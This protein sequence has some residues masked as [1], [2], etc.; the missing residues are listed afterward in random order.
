MTTHDSTYPQQAQRG[1]REAAREARGQSP[2]EIRRDIDR[3]RM[4]I[5]R[6]I[7][8]LEDALSPTRL[9]DRCVTW[10]ESSFRR[11]PPHANGRDNHDADA[12]ARNL[13]DRCASIIADH[14]VPM[15]LIA[16][17][18]GWLV[19]DSLLSRRDQRRRPL[20][21]S[22]SMVP[23]STY[24]AASPPQRPT[25]RQTDEARPS[26]TVA[27]PSGAGERPQASAPSASWAAG[28]EDGRH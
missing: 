1:Q 5:D 18:V 27:A 14:P 13:G 21:R 2:E 12:R 10:A 19:M 20:P 24:T 15:A 4:Q 16:A 7:D 6:T 25:A 8:R 9:L 22:R 11:E 3:T 23:A 17:G 28:S 26:R